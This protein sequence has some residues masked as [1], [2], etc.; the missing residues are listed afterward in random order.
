MTPQ[1]QRIRAVGNLLSAHGSAGRSSSDA[2]KTLADQLNS[3][4]KRRRKL[5]LAVDAEWPHTND[6]NAATRRALKLPLIR[7]YNP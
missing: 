2:C 3:I 6:N 5:R 1:R 7:P 4:N